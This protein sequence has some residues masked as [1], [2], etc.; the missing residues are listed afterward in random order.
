VSQSGDTLIYIAA[1]MLV[2]YLVVSGTL[3]AMRRV[4]RAERQESA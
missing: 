3:W 2:P 4:L 1:F